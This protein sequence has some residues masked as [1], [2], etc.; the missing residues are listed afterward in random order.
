M[1]KL[2]LFLLLVSAGI[3]EKAHAQI[4]AVVLNDKNGWHKI[5]NTTVSFKNDHDEIL[6][7]GSNRFVAV[8]FKVTDAPIDLEDL[9]IYFRSGDKQI[10]HFSMSFEVPGESRVI[11]LNGGERTVKK[12][13]FKYRTLPNYKDV[14]AHV[15]VW[16]LKENSDKK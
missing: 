15:E 14:K 2:L 12:I 7:L 5:G 9:E 10:V 3:L 13:V 11:D 1:K 8:K 4:P 16:G 6:I